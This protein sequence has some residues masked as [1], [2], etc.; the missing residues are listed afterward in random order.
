MLI[1]I[2]KRENKGLG[3]EHLQFTKVMED[4]NV[5]TGGVK[6]NEKNKKQVFALLYLVSVC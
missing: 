4:K 6:M 1:K 2:T 3:N 5:R